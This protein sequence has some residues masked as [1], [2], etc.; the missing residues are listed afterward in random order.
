[1]DTARQCP[2]CSGL[3]P[4]SKLAACPFCNRSSDPSETLPNARSDWKT[5]IIVVIAAAS[6]ALVGFLLR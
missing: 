4:G 6:F 1:M 3:M 5:V 2:Y